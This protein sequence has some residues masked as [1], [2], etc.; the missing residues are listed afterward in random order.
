[1]IKAYIQHFPENSQVISML[2]GK[3]TSNQDVAGLA[4]LVRLAWAGPY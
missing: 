3:F 4:P 1:M 2:P